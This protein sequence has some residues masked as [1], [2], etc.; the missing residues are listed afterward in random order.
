[1]CRV[2]YLQSIYLCCV[3]FFLILGC[4]WVD[5]INHFSCKSL[6]G[7]C[8]HIHIAMWCTNKVFK[9]SLPCNKRRHIAMW[10]YAYVP[11]RVVSYRFKFTGQHKNLYSYPFPSLVPHVQS[12]LVQF[13][14]ACHIC[15]R[16]TSS[17]SKSS[18]FVYLDHV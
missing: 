14:C 4:V 5:N 17:R 2:F 3:M 13:S 10:N 8:K 7:V 9:P 1:M 16:A 6:K 18:N 11:C 15:V 12:V